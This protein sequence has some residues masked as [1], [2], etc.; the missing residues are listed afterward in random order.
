M[1]KECDMKLYE[2]VRRNS[3]KMPH[4]ELYYY[5]LDWADQHNEIQKELAMKY[6][7]YEVCYID[8][9][10]G[11]SN[12][13]TF[14]NVNGNNPYF[15]ARRFYGE[16]LD[17]V[18]VAE[19]RHLPN[20]YISG[21]ERM[22]RIILSYDKDEKVKDALNWEYH[23][24]SNKWQADRGFYRY[25]IIGDEI[26]GYKAYASGGKTAVKDYNCKKSSVFSSLEELKKKIENKSQLW[27][28]D[29]DFDDYYGEIS[30]EV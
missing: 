21:P 5:L 13:K 3:R 12:K 17:T 4:D 28:I 9:L 19:L 15:D 10:T 26:N 8:S 23:K 1:V 6:D 20:P 30:V 11:E 22:S 7:T 2:Y 27:L 25:T 14:K 16:I 18:D 29:D 24:D